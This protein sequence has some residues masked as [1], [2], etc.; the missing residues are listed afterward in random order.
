MSKS[1]Q[2]EVAID[3]PEI[4]CLRGRY[5]DHVCKGEWH[6]V[7]KS[8]ARILG[9]CPPPYS[10]KKYS[11][12]GLALGKVQSGKTLS[13]TALIALAIDNGYRISVVLAGTKTALLEQ[14][15]TRLYRDLVTGRQK[16]TQFKNPVPLDAGVIQGVIHRQEHALVIVLKQKDHLESVRRVL[17]APELR[18]VPMLII[19]DEGD[20][21]SLNT[22]FRRKKAS[23]IYQR[24]LNL[25]NALMSHAYIAY[26]ATPQANLLVS[27][28]DNLSPDFGVL[29]E[30][31]D[32]YC[33]GSTFFDTDRDKYVRLIPDA[34]VQDEPFC[35]IPNGL[36]LALASFF[37]GCAIRHVR[38]PSTYHSMLIHS[39]DRTKD[40][41]KLKE[42]VETQIELWKE[43][44][45]LR[46]SDPAAQELFAVLE[47]AYKDLCRTVD[48]PPSWKELK[49]KIYDEIMS[50]EIWMVNSLSTGRDPISTPFRLPNNVLVGG[51]MLG[52]GVTIEGLAI[53]YITRRANKETNADTMEQR[54]RWF[55]YKRPYL[56]LCRI[57]ITRQLC[58]DYAELLRHEDDLWESLQRNE[59]QGLSI[60]DWPRMLSLDTTMGL[61]P[62]RST[63][64]NSRQ[65]RGFGWDVQNRLIEDETLAS[66]NVLAVRSFFENHTSVVRNYGNVAHLVVQSCPTDS[67]IKDLFAVVRTDGTNWERAYTNEYLMRLLLDGKLVSLDVVFMSEGNERVRTKSKRTGRVNPMQGRTPGKS[68]SDPAYYP[69]D[70]N[71]HNSRVQLQAHIIRVKGKDIPHPVETTAFALYVPGENHRY[72]LRLVVRDEST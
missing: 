14:S 68:P 24:I 25:R 61:R 29:I 45:K 49:N 71:I 5:I 41:S 64:A 42:S 16:I 56:D 36:R 23:T 66:A 32:G 51:N 13:Y 2:W 22:Q 63:V 8:A 39:S 46:D 62:T 7:V 43:T 21:A 55:G 10:N 19:D 70:L 27:G 40:H 53:T 17:T 38:G 54:A 57:Y 15:N 44:L 33:G 31:G 35:G 34:E 20:E 3:G 18:N 72:D 30:P 59:Q 37:V 48:N 52:R 6:G 69:G 1:S 11:V 47:Q 60:R 26:T 28:I 50:N 58:S 9:Y 67:V 65:F 4:E 12:T